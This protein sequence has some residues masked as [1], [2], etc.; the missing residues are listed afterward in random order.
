M[1]LKLKA[2]WL[3]GI[4]FVVKALTSGFPLAIE[5]F[6]ESLGWLSKN[7]NLS[8][9]TWNGGVWFFFGSTENH[10]KSSLK[11]YLS[12]IFVLFPYI[13]VH[14]IISV[15]VSVWVLLC[16]CCMHDSK[17]IYLKFGISVF[18]RF[19]LILIP[20]LTTFLFVFAAVSVSF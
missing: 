6:C 10:C 13:E 8:L 15:S 2:P 1:Y 18:T 16:L 3:Q 7:L 19:Y 14:F 11:L 4:R 5:H 12:Y 20:V 17:L 9:G